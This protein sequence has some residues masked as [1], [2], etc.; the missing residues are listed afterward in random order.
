[1]RKFYR[2]PSIGVSCKILL[3]KAVSEEKIPMCK[4]N[5]QTK[6]DKMMTNAHISLWPSELKRTKGQT[7]IYKTL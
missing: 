7:M 3:N 5:R 1:M 6:D 2:G 4:V